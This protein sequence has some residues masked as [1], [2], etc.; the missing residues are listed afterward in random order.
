MI[1][2][3]EVSKRQNNSLR[4]LFPFYRCGRG[5]LSDLNDHDE[6]VLCEKLLKNFKNI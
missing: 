5:R 3:R 4:S 6:V 2:C 1:V